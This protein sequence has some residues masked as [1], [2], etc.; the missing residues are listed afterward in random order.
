[1]PDRND[2]DLELLTPS[3]ATRELSRLGRPLSEA[4]FKRAVDRGEIPSQRTRGRGV[5]LVTL[6]DVR[7]YAKARLA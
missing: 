5:R 4:S 6:G 3:F 2:D 7:A 1:M